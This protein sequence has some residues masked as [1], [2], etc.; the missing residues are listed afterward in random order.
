MTITTSRR[1]SHN[2][3]TRNGSCGVVFPGYISQ[4]ECRGSQPGRSRH[5]QN[6]EE[7]RKW[8]PVC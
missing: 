8:P 5:E 3:L 6:D 4:D 1:R 7:N 2:F